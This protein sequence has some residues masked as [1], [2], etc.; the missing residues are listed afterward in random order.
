M[1]GDEAQVRAADP[2]AAAVRRRA[3]L[4]AAILHGLAV[5]VLVEAFAPDLAIRTVQ[6]AVATFAASPE[7]APSPSPSPSPPAP[8]GRAAAGAGGTGGKRAIPR[9]AA[10]PP[11]RQVIERQPP[12]PPVAATGAQDRAGAQAAGAGTGAAGAGGGTGS[13]G[14][15]NGQG[16]ASAAVKIAGDINSA[17][18]YPIASRELRIGDHVIIALTVGTDGRPAACR[19]VRASRDPEADAITCR[20]AMAR[21]RFRPATDA[22]GQAVVSTYGWQQRWFYRDEP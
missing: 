16:G 15:G 5:I 20:L 8:S 6:R 10:V 13:G 21:F 14:A 7:P 22:A 18:D 3:F 4:L 17:R 11:P 2:A 12:A 19:V 1:K 9:A